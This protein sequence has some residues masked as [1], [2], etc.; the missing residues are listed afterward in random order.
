MKRILSFAFLGIFAALLLSLVPQ[1][2]AQSGLT[3][4]A[5][6]YN[7]TSLTGTAIRQTYNNV[8]F[9][10][11][12]GSPIS[13]I[14]ADNWSAR[15]STVATFNQGTYRFTI[16]ADD[17][18]R[19]YVHGQLYADTWNSTQVGQ[20]V[21]TD[22]NLQA[23]GAGIVID[24]RDNTANAFLSVSW[25]QISGNQ[26]P[27]PTGSWVAE[28][29]NNASL[30]N[31]PN[32]VV[33]EA[34]PNHDWGTGAPANGI[35]ADNFSARW[36][37]QQNFTAGNYRITVTVD[38][39]VRVNVNGVRVIDEWH[40][41]PTIATY[42]RDVTLFTGL[43]SFVIEYYEASGI[44]RIQ[45][46]VTPVSSIPPTVPP[47]TVIASVTVNSPLLNVRS[48]PVIAD[49]IINKVSQ[50]ATY[51]VIGRNAEGTWWQ[52]QI[53]TQIGW[54]SGAHVIASNTQNVPVV[55]GGVSN[56]TPAPNTPTAQVT[57][58]TGLLNVRS[59]PFV[60]DNIIN[61]IP[62]GASYTVI[63]RNADTSWWQIQLG[64]QV[65]W[66][67]ARY[68]IPAN[69]QNVPVV[70]VTVEVPTA[71]STGTGYL[72]TATANLNIRAGAG[73]TF[74]RLNILPANRQAE[75]LARNSNNTWWLVRY[76]GTTG[77]VS[78]A[79]VTLPAGIDF[80]RIPIQ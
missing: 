31:N 37:S 35:G 13:G 67:S 17:G 34:S 1:A 30:S 23:G 26:N 32:V 78:G 56:P 10:W 5:D 24:F 14:Q 20:T 64:T 6:F 77:W 7:N 25:M 52:I 76:G 38:D 22:I 63:G 47:S 18:F 29:W 27:V 74:N 71:P 60:G 55:T 28:Y 19:L 41:S 8:N 46:S 33:A 16:T 12:S 36:S 80:N 4:T 72:L 57:V 21:T 61:K 49:N 51:P 3:W 69:T 40:G 50:G 75:I 68:V 43:N 54:V 62:R 9:N 66:V 11:G 2:Q 45:F 79:F 44:A 70:N 48:A 73:A 53:G 58:N 39:G 42:T 59:A 15:F 65:G